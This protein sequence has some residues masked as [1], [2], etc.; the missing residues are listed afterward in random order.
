MRMFG[1]DITLHLKALGPPP[2]ATPV[3][4]RSVGRSWWPVIHEPYTGAW[5]RNDEVAVGDAL[6]YFAVFACVTLIASDIGKLHLALVE[7]N[8]DGI[9]TEVENSAYSPVLRRPNRYQNTIKFVEQWITSKL[10]NGNAYVL[11]QRDLRGVVNAL[12]VLDPSRVTPL[13]ASDGSVFYQLAGDDLAGLTEAALVDTTT[14]KARNTIAVPAREIIHDLMVALY[15]PL[16]GVSPIYACGLAAMQGLKIQANSAAFFANGSKPGG[17]LTAPG[18]ISDETAG[19]LKEYWETNF[20]GQNA[21]RVAVL[22]DGLKYEAMTVNPV[23]ADMVNQLKW[24]ASTVCSCFHVPPYMVNIG[25]APPYANAEPLLQQYFS[26]CLQS[27]ITNFETCLDEGLETPRGIGTQFDID[28]L[29]WMDTATKT[30]AANEGIGGGALAPDE[31]R[32][33]YYGLGPVLGG[34][35]PYMQ[36]QYFSLRALAERD[37]T[38]PL[39]K[40]AAPAPTADAVDLAACARAIRLKAAELLHVA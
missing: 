2:S 22:G 38:N 14:G 1:Y 24:T 3:T 10:T 13:V 5:Q 26:Q 39:A 30:K 7:Q 17:V 29:I 20:S 33:K 6:A 8:E 36:Q 28:D 12:Y 15:H 34:D 16:I 27:L 19:R 31:A 18:A 23:D 11:K 25:D 21:G 40:P 4:A 9:W 35:T 37:A 32:F